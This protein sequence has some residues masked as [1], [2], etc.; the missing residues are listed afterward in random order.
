MVLIAKNGLFQVW[1]KVNFWSGSLTE[2]DNRL[3]LRQRVCFPSLSNT[4]TNRYLCKDPKENI[5]S[6]SADG[7]F[8]MGPFRGEYL[9]KSKVYMPSLDSRLNKQCPNNGPKVFSSMKSTR[10]SGQLNI[11]NFSPNNFVSSLFASFNFLFL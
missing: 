7:V 1:L 4:S 8:S 6:T 5:E 9:G 2:V 10:K 11:M 3:C